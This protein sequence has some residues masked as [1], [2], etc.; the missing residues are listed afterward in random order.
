MGQLLQSKLIQLIVKCRT[1]TNVLQ[2]RMQTVP[3]MHKILCSTAV[4]T[5]ANTMNSSNKKKEEKKR[6]KVKMKMN[7]LV[8]V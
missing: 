5:D 7:T 4:N 6:M 8:A 3:L 2:R 1:T